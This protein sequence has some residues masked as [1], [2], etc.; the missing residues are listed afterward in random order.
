MARPDEVPLALLSSHMHVLIINMSAFPPGIS[1]KISNAYS[2][3][4]HNYNFSRLGTQDS[5]EI[6]LVGFSRGAFAV[7]CLASLLSQT[8]LLQSQ[9]LYYLRG[10]F[11]LWANQKFKMRAGDEPYIVRK[12]LE[13]YVQKLRDESLLHEVRIKA[14]VVWET[15][16]ALGLPVHLSPRPLSFVGEQVPCVVENAFH[17]LALHE[18]RAQFKPRLWEFIEPARQIHG[19]TIQPNAKQCWFLGSHGDIGG[20]WDAALGA[21]TLIWMLSQLESANTGV[22]FDQDEIAKHLEHKL[23]EWDFKFNRMFNRIIGQLNET[24]VLSAISSS[25]IVTPFINADWINF[26][27]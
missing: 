22:T 11:T 24:S 12:K 18:K 17:A 13:D 4:S 1:T 7:Q 15:V 2:F 19:V 8:G 6:F 26:H 20:N 27:V 23:L 10:L 9:H 16:S 3:I 14:L 25:G 21:V 5:D